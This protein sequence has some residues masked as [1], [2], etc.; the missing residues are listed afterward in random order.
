MVEF[1]ITAMNTHT[2]PIYLGCICNPQAIASTSLA[3]IT[4]SHSEWMRILAINRYCARKLM[5]QAG[6]SQDKATIKMRVPIAKMLGRKT[7]RTDTE[8]EGGSAVGGA[9]ISPFSV[10]QLQVIIMNTDGAAESGAR[11]IPV[12][13]TANIFMTFF[14]RDIEFD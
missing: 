7:Y 4:F 5:T 10:A 1:T 11:T 2:A 12:V 8:F 14:G 13:I 3:V 9:A 6:G